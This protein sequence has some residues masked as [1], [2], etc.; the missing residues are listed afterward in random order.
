MKDFQVAGPITG[1]ESDYQEESTLQQPPGNEDNI[2][3]W[4]RVARLAVLKSAEHRWGQVIIS[5]VEA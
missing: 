3:R 5:Q 4:Q 2:A 1:L